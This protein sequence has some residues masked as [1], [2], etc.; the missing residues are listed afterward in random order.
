MISRLS[1]VPGNVGCEIRFTRPDIH[2][3]RGI[4]NLHGYTF[5]AFES[6]IFNATEFFILIDLGKCVLRWPVLMGVK[7]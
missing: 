6:S 1:V 3:K 5:A 2:A 7:G 4:I